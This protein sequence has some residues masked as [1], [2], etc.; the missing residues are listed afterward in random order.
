MA[1]CIVCGS[2]SSAPFSSKNGY[3]V[4][5]CTAC[6]LKYMYPL[7]AASISGDIYD[8][9]YFEGAGK[10]HGYVN[11]DEDK[12]PMRSAFVK[13]LDHIRAAIG[14]KGRLL[15]VGAA[16]GYF[17]ALAKDAGYAAEGV[18]ISDHAAS[19]GRAKGLTVR[20]GVIDD[21]EGVFDC[22]TM[23]DLIEHVPDPR[24]VL[25]KAAILLRAGGVLVINTPDAGSL[26]ARILGRNWHAIIPPEHIYYFDRANIKCLLEEAGFEILKETSIVKSF[27]FKYIF[28]TLHQSMHIPLFLKVSSLFSHKSLSKISIPI[29]L[30]DNMFVLAR[31]K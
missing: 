19:V 24:A 6:G 26:V 20:T 14:P 30:H 2:T 21:V 9:D 13:Y 17:V 12:E 11:Y 10:G 27:T 1:T 15:D 16:T 8:R 22:V 23:L 28:K 5:R 25:K 31:K 4:L 29:N 7:P 18:D 3:Q